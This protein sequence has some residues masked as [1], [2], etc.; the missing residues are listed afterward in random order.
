MFATIQK[1][2]LPSPASGPER[3]KNDVVPPLTGSSWASGST[4]HVVTPMSGP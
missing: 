2:A 1:L 3:W 4:I